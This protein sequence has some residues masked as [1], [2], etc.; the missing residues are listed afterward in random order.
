MAGYLQDS[1]SLEQAIIRLRGALNP[2][3]YLPSADALTPQTS[4]VIVP[5]PNSYAREVRELEEN[6]ALYAPL[7]NLPTTSAY[8]QPHP[9]RRSTGGAN[10]QSQTH[11]SKGDTGGGDVDTDME[12]DDA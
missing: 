7:T 8:K 4:S 2:T 1:A 12:E 6:L 11:R 5:T 10:Q 9:V 3:Q